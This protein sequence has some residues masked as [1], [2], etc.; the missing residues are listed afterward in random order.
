MSDI[1]FA[2]AGLVISTSDGTHRR[3]ELYSFI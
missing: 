2:V 1:C 3:K